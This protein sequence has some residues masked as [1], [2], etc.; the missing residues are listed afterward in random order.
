[1]IS[2]L[3]NF[4][5]KLFTVRGFSVASHLLEQHKKPSK[6]TVKGKKRLRKELH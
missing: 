4:Y 3:Q 2:I 1:M 6:S 5:K